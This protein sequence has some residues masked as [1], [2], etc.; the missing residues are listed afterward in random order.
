MSKVLLIED[1]KNIREAIHEI[2][3]LGGY[4]VTSSENGRIGIEEAKKFIPDLVICDIMMPELDGWQTIEIFR[5]IDTF[6]HVPFVF[7]SAMPLVPNYRLGMNSG[8][9]DFIVKPIDTY[10]L[11]EIVDRLIS[12]SMKRALANDTRVKNALNT[13]KE[14]IK[15]NQ[16]DYQDSLNRA[17]IVQNGILPAEEKMRE[18]FQ[19]HFLY[20]NPLQTVSGDFYWTKEVNGVKLIAVADCTGHGVPA[21]LLSMACSTMLNVAFDLFEIVSP[22]KALKKVNELVVEFMRENQLEYEGDGMDISLCAIDQKNNKIT[23]SGAKRPLYFIPKEV[24]SLNG[25]AQNM[26]MHENKKGDK[27]VEF[28]GSAY[29]IGCNDFTIEEFSFSYEPGD[30]LYLFSDGYV[31]QFGGVQSKKFNSKNLR[32]LLL[33]IQD[34]DIEQQGYEMKHS[35][36]LWKGEEEQTDDVTI[37]GITL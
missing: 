19:E 20:Y 5:S 3:E 34:L 2:L 15:N 32:Q 9:D 35:F 28:R 22:S 24:R 17:K 8:A 26:R 1:D 10:E 18:M 31:S 29:S 7:L 27:L 12:K 14:K 23:Y 33:S 4:E 37:I 11:L 25:A 36:E 16:K 13:F 6:E 30:N 21:A